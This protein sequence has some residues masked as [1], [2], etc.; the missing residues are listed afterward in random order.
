VR[1]V[2]SSAARADLKAIYRRSAELFGPNQA[3]VYSAGLAK[4]LGRIAQYPRSGRIRSE[5]RPPLRTMPH[6]SHV[7][8]YRITGSDVRVVRIRAAE[9][10]WMS[11]PLGV[12][13][14]DQEVS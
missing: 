7:I 6:K 3:D 13:D 11:D 1:L 10:D 5:I 12:Q 4:T 9:E 8:L 14:D 2:L